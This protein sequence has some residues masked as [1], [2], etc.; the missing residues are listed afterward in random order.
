[1]CEKL[2][3]VDKYPAKILSEINRSSS[4]LRD[5]FDDNFT[6]I[7]VDDSEMFSEIAWFDTKNVRNKAEKNLVIK[8]I[9]IKNLYK[10]LLT[11]TT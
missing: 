10:F 2:T 7:H 1:M 5:I 6:G 9:T 8:F 4:I 11:I 3:K